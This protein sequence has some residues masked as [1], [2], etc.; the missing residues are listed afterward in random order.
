VLDPARLA[1]LVLLHWEGDE[2]GGMDRFMREAPGA[3]LGGS[4]LSIQLN[5]AS[6]GVDTERV[7]SFMD[8]E[9][10]ELGRHMLRFLETPHVHHWDS[11][12]VF[13]ESTGSLFPIRPVPAAGRPTAGRERKPV[14]GDARRLPRDRDLRPR[15]PGAHGRG[16]DRG[17]R[18]DVDPRDA[19]RLAEGRRLHYYNRALREEEFAYNG[20]LLGRDINAVA[21]A[22]A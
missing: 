9:R 12:V 5:A 14:R 6:F 3:E 15:E 8:G 11:M 7:R 1:N 22:A 18:P 10:L 19:R 21:A 13:E 17:A 4:A 20:L 16:P 2:N